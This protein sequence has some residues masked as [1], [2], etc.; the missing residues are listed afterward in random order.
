MSDVHV[1]PAAPAE[2]DALARLL[3]LYA[4]DFSERTGADV[5]DDGTFGWRDLAAWWR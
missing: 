3:E 2:R 5:G 1:D 4:H